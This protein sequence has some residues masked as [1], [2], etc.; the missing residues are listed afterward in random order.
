MTTTRHIPAQATT[1]WGDSGQSSRSHKRVRIR[2]AAPP[3]AAVLVITLALIA[4][5]AVH[6]VVTLVVSAVLVAIAMASVALAGPGRATREILIGAAAI[7]VTAISGL[8]GPLHNAAPVLAAIFA[9]G[10]AWTIGYLAAP[11]RHALDLVWTTLIWSAIIYCVWIFITYVST[12]QGPTSGIAYAF[13]TAANGAVV[14]GMLAVIAMGRVL[15]ILKQIDAERL[16]P[17]QMIERLLRDGVGAL[18]LLFAALACLILTGSRSGMMFAGAVLL[19]YAWWDLLSITRRVHR[20]ITLLILVF[21]I[22]LLATALAVWGVAQGWTLDDAVSAG[23]GSSEIPSRLQR[24]DAYAAAWLE[25]PLT[26]HGLGSATIEGA[27]YHTLYN[28]KAMLAPGGAQNLGVSWLVEIGV[29]GLGILLFVLGAIHLRIVSA[30]T[31]R[32]APRSFARMA[33]AASILLLLHG[34]THSSL[35]IPAVGW[36]YAFLL[37]CACGLATRQR[38]NSR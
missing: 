8:A 19:A 24:L 34:V 16:G 10:C 2:D 37:G 7:A 28:A 38:E 31:S 18:L 20:G 32:R 17:A 36:L 3:V 12:V 29:I 13:E 14:F 23:I 5:G 21:G 33:I 25:S 15:H 1:G 4:S 6:P 26:G 30:L 9:A 22:P 27:R 11:R 35:N